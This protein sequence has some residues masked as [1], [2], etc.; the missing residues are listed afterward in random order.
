MLELETR[1][2]ELVAL[3]LTP[4]EADPELGYIV[5]G[6]SE[7]DG[8]AK[9]A[10]FVEE[11]SAEL[12]QVLVAA[13]ALWNAFIVAADARTLLA[14]YE[15]R[16]A[17]VVAAMR[18]AVERDACVPND[19]IAAQ[20]LYEKLPTIDFSRRVMEGAES[21]LRVLSV[22]PCGWSDLGT[23]RRV[24]E[25]LQRSRSRVSE[26]DSIGASLTGF[27]SLAAQHARSVAHV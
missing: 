1:P 26:W 25:T 11:P 24:A 15:T 12:A 16:F 10:R 7:G 14:T 8:I 21:M 3:G 5:P 19:P 9:V 22:P 20:S 4:E 13:G 18:T 17:D 23:P 2:N 27:L 6:A